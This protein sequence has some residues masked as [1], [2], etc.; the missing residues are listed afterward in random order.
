MFKE[1]PEAPIESIVEKP[2]G[3][4]LFIEASG[5]TPKDG[6]SLRALFKNVPLNLSGIETLRALRTTLITKR[7]RYDETA[8][9]AQD[10]CRRKGGNCLGLSLLFGGELIERGFTP[11]FSM[12]TRPK[13][14]IARKEQELFDRLLTG[15]LLDYDRPKLPEQQAPH[16]IFRF[17]PLGHPQIHIDGKAFETTGLEDA[18]E[19]PEWNPDAETI[20]QLSYENLCGAVPSELAK[21]M[22]RTSKKDCERSSKLAKES[23]EFWPENV[24][25]FF[26]LWLNASM[27]DDG[28]G[29]EEAKHEYLKRVNGTSG[30][31]W[32]AYC[33]TKDPALLTQAL[34]QYPS[35]LFPFI[36]KH[37]TLEP[38]AREARF[39]LAVAAWCAGNSSV[40]SLQDFYQ[41]YGEEIKRLFGHSTRNSLLHR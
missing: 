7:F 21:Q 25:A 40:I 35:F 22:K 34:K 39:H 31:L 10:M 17:G 36:E 9:R 15:G 32:G 2:T 28:R 3:F 16:P 20:A 29:A 23:L 8:F 14:A 11:T 24:D 1:K 27:I 38:D 33:M 6:Q 37:V 18:E 5:A 41:D 19:N 12:I 26:T 13:D 4:S 30:M